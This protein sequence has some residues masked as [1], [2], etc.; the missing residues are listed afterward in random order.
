MACWEHTLTAVC[1][2]PV[3]GTVTTERYWALPGCR[4]LEPPRLFSGSRLHTW[5]LG[6]Q[7]SELLAVAWGT[8]L[9]NRGQ[10]RVGVGSR[11]EAGLYILG[12]AV[13]PESQALLP[14]LEPGL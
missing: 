8:A 14:S 12:Q 2:C 3:S 10:A 7:F 9:A 1:V 13:W 11:A 5:G 4:A 6:W